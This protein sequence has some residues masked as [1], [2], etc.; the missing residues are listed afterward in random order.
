MEAT[1]SALQAHFSTR[2]VTLFF[3]NQKRVKHTGY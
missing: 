1:A 2:A 3:T